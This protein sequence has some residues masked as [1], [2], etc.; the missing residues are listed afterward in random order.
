M[1][2]RGAP[3]ARDHRCAP[4]DECKV[5][6]VTA[7]HVPANT[8]TPEPAIESRARKPNTAASSL[9]GTVNPSTAHAIRPLYGGGT[10]PDCRSAKAKVPT[11][12]PRKPNGNDVP[13]GQTT[14]PVARSGHLAIGPRKC[15]QSAPVGKSRSGRGDAGESGMVR[16]YLRLS[17][18][19]RGGLV[20]SDALRATRPDGSSTVGASHRE[21]SGFAGSHCWTPPTASEFRERE[22]GRM[23]IVS[24]RR[25]PGPRARS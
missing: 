9:V 6:K 19:N 22:L 12:R 16:R 10:D 8:P 24:S 21:S 18:A 13:R 5:T 11:H 7:A 14:M 3:T 15:S 20:P 17:R 23:S 1:H 25:R 4:G 2:P